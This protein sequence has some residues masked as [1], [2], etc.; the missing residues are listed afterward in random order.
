MMIIFSFILPGCGK[1]APPVPPQQVAS[2]VAVT[3][4]L[5]LNYEKN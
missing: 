1:K 2:P 3:E 5:R 4:K